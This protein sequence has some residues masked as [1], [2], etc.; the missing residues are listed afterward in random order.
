MTRSNGLAVRAMTARRIDWSAISGDVALA[1]LGEPNARLSTVR[2]WRYGRRGSLA[3]HVAGD[4]AGTWRDFE[5]LLG[6]PNARL[7]TV[8]EWRYGRRGSLAVHVAGDRAGTWRDF[9]SDCGR[10][11]CWPGGSKARGAPSRFARR[12]AAISPTR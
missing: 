2:E 1:L 11:R 4:R 6:E 12:V 10:R 8:R 5:S 7:S 9:E 3:V